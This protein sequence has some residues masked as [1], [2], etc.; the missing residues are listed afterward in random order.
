MSKLTN[1]PHSARERAGLWPILSTL[2]LRG[3]GGTP[4]AP[5]TAPNPGDPP[6]ALPPIDLNHPGYQAHLAT[7]LKGFETEK[8][9]IIGNRDQILTEKKRIEEALGGVKPEELQAKL[10]KI[11][12]IEANERAGIHGKT[13]DEWLAAVEAE[14]QKKHAVWR[15]EQAEVMA[16]GK[17][18]ISALEQELADAK[19]AEMRSWTAYQL[20]LAALP[21]DYRYIQPG[22]EDMLLD[23]LVP[24]TERY[25]IEGVPAVPR[26]KV[27][28]TL[29]TGSGPDGY[30][31]MR[32]LL[33]LGRQGKIP[34]QPQFQFL[35]ASA[36][37]GSGTK[38]PSAPGGGAG[39]GNWWTM[40]DDAKNKYINEHGAA[41]AKALMDSSERPTKAA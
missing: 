27:G 40:S 38:T 20:A 35:F 15:E 16:Q 18:R 32:E 19:N 36:G 33:E 34:N 13:G 14:A 22:A 1:H 29:L 10:K 41:A 28:G 23:R 39:G 5:P 8:A 11:A 26:F 17:L 21:E 2:P 12:E 9:A 4:P 24:I 30:M 31:T 6:P 7:I 25:Q 3:E 37:Q